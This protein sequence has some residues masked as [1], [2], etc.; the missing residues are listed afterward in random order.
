LASRLVLFSWRRAAS[1]AVLLVRRDPSSVSGFQHTVVSVS[2]RLWLSAV[3][4]AGRAGDLNPETSPLSTTKTES[5]ALRHQ[6][7]AG[8]PG[9]GHESRTLAANLTVESCYLGAKDLDR[10]PKRL[11]ANA[12]GAREL[13]GSQP[14]GPKDA[15]QPC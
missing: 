7:S 15:E 5:T 8:S 1:A 10:V 2:R 3:Q 6:R 11:D 4:R 13:A 12:I 9:S 14:L